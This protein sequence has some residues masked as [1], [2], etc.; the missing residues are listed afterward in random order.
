MPVKKT[1]EAPNLSAKRLAGSRN[2]ATTSE[3]MLA[4]H[5]VEELSRLKISVNLGNNRRKPL[6]RYPSRNRGIAI[7]PTKTISAHAKLHSSVRHSPE[8]LSSRGLELS[9]PSNR[10]VPD[11]LGHKLFLLLSISLAVS[12]VLFEV[13]Y[14]M[15]RD[16]V[17]GTEIRRSMESR[18]RYRIGQNFQVATCG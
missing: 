3:K 8:G 16:V 17:N 18:R 15:I 14:A 6:S 11:K 10:V 12:K 7:E 9:A 13:S 1:G 4:S 5:V 2:D